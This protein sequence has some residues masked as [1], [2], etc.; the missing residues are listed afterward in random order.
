IRSTV[1]STQAKSPVG[2]GDPDV[3]R[4]G[5]AVLDVS[6]YQASFGVGLM[7]EVIEDQLWLGIGYQAQPGLGPMALKGTLRTTYADGATLFPV[8][9][10][11]ALP[12]SI[13]VGG[14]Y[15]PNARLELRL[16]AELT[17]WSV[18]ASQ[19]VGFEGQP[20]QV[21]STG[22]DATP[23]GST[24]QNLRRRWKDSYGVRAGASTWVSPR[25][26]LFGGAGFETAATP[27]ETLD[28]GLADANNV[29][30][31]GG[32]RVQIGGTFVSATYTHIQYFDR[33][34]TGQSTL[35]DALTPTKRPDGGGKYT[36]WVGLFNVNL[37]RQF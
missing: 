7:A 24:I 6:G 19:C 13:R 21:D 28:P 4:E 17:R 26:E 12:D 2:T 33:D 34:N 36:Q 9:F 10:H 25:V 11:Q 32:A 15:R 31:A 20:C 22:A 8:E 35:A 3:T 18:M 30:G 5:R 16:S 27:K 14:H 1:T 23:Q 37:Q 29:A